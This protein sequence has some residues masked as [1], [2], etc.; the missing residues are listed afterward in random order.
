MPSSAGSLAGKID[1]KE[2]SMDNSPLVTPTH[3]AKGTILSP[4][5]AI[6]L[7]PDVVSFFTPCSSPLFFVKLG[8]RFLFVP[9]LIANP[10]VP[11]IITER[12]A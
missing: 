4:Q 7:L 11:K 1:S 9:C 6:N 3:Q 5:K 12:A 10:D 8:V 2:A